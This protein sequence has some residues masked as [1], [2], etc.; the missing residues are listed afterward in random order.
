MSNTPT[1]DAPGSGGPAHGLSGVAMTLL[2]PL[3]GR[4]HAAA[5]LPGTAFRDPA[6]AS[7]LAAT[8]YRAP[9]VLTDRGNALG[10]VHRAIVFDE[11]TA[12]F[13]REHPDAV[14]V[15]AGIGLDTRAE[16][17]A[18]ALPGSVTWLGVDVPDV[19]ALRARLLPGDLTRVFPASI[20]EPG[21]A[22]RLLPLV[23]ER[24][25]VLVL[26]EGVL[27]YLDPAGLRS[28]LLSCRTAFPAAELVADHPR[29]ALSGLH[30]IVKA[31][32]A[33]FRSGARG[34]R[35]LAAAAPG[36]EKVSDHRFMERISLG[37]RAACS[38]CSPPA[39]RPT[40]WPGCG[41][42]RRPADARGQQVGRAVSP[43]RA[44]SAGPAAPG[45]GA[46]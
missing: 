23:G 24:R 43:S 40:P 29:I 44:A 42:R 25:N 33:R 36:W 17:L 10:P 39:H 27:M 6:A 30:P 22:Q 11:L 28:F 4:A 37:H 45:R 32:G 18:G 14:V 21:W 7:E 9:E 12:A 19:V 38:G 2:T 20:T 15:S 16:R 1:P 8:G 31:T 35:G 41:P 13:C 3:H 34:G 5:L 26:T 46:G